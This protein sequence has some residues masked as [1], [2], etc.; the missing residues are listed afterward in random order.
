MIDVPELV[1]HAGPVDISAHVLFESLA[2]TLGLPSTDS[3]GCT[4]AT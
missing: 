4:A 3:R 1:I 2:Y